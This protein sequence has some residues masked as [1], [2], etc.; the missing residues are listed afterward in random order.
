MALV[1]EKNPDFSWVFWPQHQRLFACLPSPKDMRFVGGAV[2]NTLL[3][4]P[5][6]DF[7]LATIHSPHVM[8]ELLAK[9]GL[10][11]IATGLAHGT[12]TV[13]MG[14]KPYEIT[15]LR[16]DEH[17]DGRH[18]EIA[19]TT[20]WTEDAHRRDF[21]MNAL[22]IDH[23]GQLFDDVGGQKDLA[24]GCVRFIGN[25]DQRIGE[26]HLRILRFFRFWAWYGRHADPESLEASC[27]LAPLMSRLSG[28]RITKE[29]L[30]LLQS[31]CPWPALLALSSHN[32]FP[33]IFGAPQR[34]LGPEALEA[35]EAAMGQCLP[36]LVRVA[37][38]C[39]DFP[40]RLVLSRVQA[41]TLKNLMVPLSN[42]SASTLRQEVYGSD[43]TT[44]RWRV[45]LWAMQAY[46]L[47]G[48]SSGEMTSRSRPDWIKC[49]QD[50]LAILDRG[51]WPVFPLSGK[52][53]VA[54]GLRGPDISLV[55]G[56]VKAWWVNQGLDNQGLDDQGLDNQGSDN[57][58]NPQSTC[59]SPSGDKQS[60]D[61]LSYELSYDLSCQ[62]SC[63]LANAKPACLAQ[64]QKIADRLAIGRQEVIQE[65]VQGVLPRGW[66]DRAQG[67]P[68]PLASGK[69][70]ISSSI[71][72]SASPSIS[73]STSP[74]G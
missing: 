66:T 58:G 20:S 61:Q 56:R 31:S 41:R 57:Q 6:D 7:D 14:S 53:L 3:G 17:T 73:L 8:I 65:V 27:R 23:Q 67:H 45:A 1:L 54:M 26:D 19:F 55:L 46:R 10:S 62:L 33:L 34:F 36:D 13:V 12:I 32:I 59:V 15:T 28:E 64:A 74:R 16:R 72:S 18:A 2:R 4:L 49:L 11:A 37:A 51:P 60:S 63:Q 30:R 9:V 52:D 68:R 24:Q 39:T 22:Y 25:P 35:V 69:S 70:S 42:L 50:A 40:Q 47:K 29:T 21:T 48:A 5:P 38:L 71:I 43:L 44:V